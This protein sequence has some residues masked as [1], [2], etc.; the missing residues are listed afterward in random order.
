MC[1]I[2]VG[3]VVGTF[4]FSGAGVFGTRQPSFRL[5]RF[6]LFYKELFMAK[7]SEI[8][9]YF[10]EGK[11]SET[12]SGDD[13]DNYACLGEAATAPITKNASDTMNKM[14][15]LCQLWTDAE[16]SGDEDRAGKIFDMVQ[17]LIR[18]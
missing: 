4:N 6:L 1:V 18:G 13:L 7:I 16:A 10:S 9:K 14:E 5:P 8:R 11:S 2:S 17:K 3:Y 15:R 12:F